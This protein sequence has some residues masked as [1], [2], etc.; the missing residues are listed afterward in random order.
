MHLCQ[1][2]SYN[3]IY[4]ELCFILLFVVTIFNVIFF[5]R[6]TKKIDEC[7]MIKNS[8][9]AMIRKCFQNCHMFTILGYDEHNDILKE[10]R[11]FRI[12]FMIYE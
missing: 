6:Q 10:N 9:C 7:A 11:I 3:T 2:V 4:I 1:A 12:G 5:T 8:E